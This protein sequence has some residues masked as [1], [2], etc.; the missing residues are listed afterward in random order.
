MNIQTLK[1][2]KGLHRPITF[3][4]AC[5]KGMKVCRGNGWIIKDCY[6]FVF[7]DSCRYRLNDNDQYD[8][9]KLKGYCFGIL[10][11]HKDSARIV[12]RYNPDTDKIELGYY[13]Y[14]NGNLTHNMICSVSIG[15][16]VLLKIEIWL[17]ESIGCYFHLKG[18]TITEEFDKSKF[19][20]G[21]GLYFGGNRRSPKTMKIKQYNLNF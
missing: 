3:V 19:I 16:A 5:F 6:M 18:V 13:I 14:K 15:D 10:G 11:I 9:N 20:F 1:I 7:D 2:P 4:P 8:W 17:G 21:C 12:W